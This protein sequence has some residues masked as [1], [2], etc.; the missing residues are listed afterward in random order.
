VYKRQVS[1]PSN[2]GGYPNSKHLY[3]SNPEVVT[4]DAA[5]RDEL[6]NAPPRSESRRAP[7]EISFKLSIPPPI[8]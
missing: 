6:S 4:N 3:T 5:R 1:N 2:I 8:H 7:K